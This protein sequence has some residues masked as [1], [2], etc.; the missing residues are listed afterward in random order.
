MA[1]LLGGL[2]R[3]GTSFDS[4]GYIIERKTDFWELIKRRVLEIE[5]RDVGKASF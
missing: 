4:F 1:G 2:G 3:S 5:E